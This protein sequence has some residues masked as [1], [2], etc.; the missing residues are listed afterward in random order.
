MQ[1]VISPGKGIGCDVVARVL[2]RSLVSDD[3]V[4][5]VALPNR[6][7]CCITQDIDAFGRGQLEPDDE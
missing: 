5:V 2:E 7:A 1:L 4:I 3:V 6:C